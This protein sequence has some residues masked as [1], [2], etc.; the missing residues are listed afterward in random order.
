MLIIPLEKSINWRKPPIVTFL[1]IIINTAILIF[2]QNQNETVLKETI[3][4]YVSS[5]LPVIEL[6]PYIESK[7]NAVIDDINNEE[8]INAIKNKEAEEDTLVSV[9]M[10]ME[11]DASFM[12]K[13][14][15]D[16][17]INQQNAVYTQW[18]TARTQFETLKDSSISS[19]YSFI[20]SQHKP[21]T[22]LSYQFLH[23]SYD[24]LIGNMIFLFLIGF[25][26]ET[27]LGSLLYLTCYL[28]S[29]LGAVTLYWQVYSNSDISL[30]GASGAIAGLMGMYAGVFGLRK[31]RFFYSFLFYFD[32]IKAP[33]LIMLPLWVANEI[34][35]LFF[36]VGSHVA[37]MAH[38]GGLLTGGII[39]FTIKHYFTE[40]ID[41]EYLD[42]S[43]K[44]DEKTL[45]YQQGMKFL[46]ELKIPQAQRIFSDLYAQ[47]PNDTDILMQYYKTLKYTTEIKAYHEIVIKLFETANIYNV[48]EINSIF[49][50]YIKT[51]KK[52]NISAKLLIKLAQLFNKN[53]Q[54]EAEL[55]IKSL[56]RKSA[57]IEGLSQA[58][59][60]LT[61]AYQRQG[62]TEKHQMC[63]NLLAQ[64]YPNQRVGMNM[65]LHN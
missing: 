52:V 30:V 27:A 48:N 49:K 3:H 11:N 34:Y 16:Q 57:D 64:Y 13:L 51:T 62:N 18:K 36:T 41:T 39:S 46:R 9:L 33:A 37:Y 20:P 32:F 1:L 2:T 21:I 5:E 53:N 15:K 12:D 45:N 65:N 55:I 58:L 47:Y 7:T 23:G 61:M 56:L 50:E 54:T 25:A 24:H 17:I 26:L 19:R 59:V 35:Q 43:D 10:A 28:V 44:N 60:A 40:K 38:V 63:L 42:E 6:P 29:G 8:L 14:H 22:F 4:Y 31:I